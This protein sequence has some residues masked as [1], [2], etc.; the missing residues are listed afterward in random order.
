MRSSSASTSATSIVSPS[1]LAVMSST[2]PGPKNQ[3]SGSASM[4]CAGSPPM[5]EL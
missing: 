4:V 2:T 1:S 3:S 5:R